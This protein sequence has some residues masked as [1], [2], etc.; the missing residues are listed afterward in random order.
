[1]RKIQEYYANKKT[2]KT[3]QD[4]IDKENE[5]PNILFIDQKRYIK[6][7]SLLNQRSNYN[8]P[9]RKYYCCNNFRLK[10]IVMDNDSLSVGRI[11]REAA[12]RRSNR[13]LAQTRI[14]QTRQDFISRLRTY[15]YRTNPHTPGGPS[16]EPVELNEL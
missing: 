3:I 16:W 15:T 14:T 5:K 13:R 10:I 2:N 12:Y 11:V 7:V 6:L 9:I 1:L 4:F 8:K